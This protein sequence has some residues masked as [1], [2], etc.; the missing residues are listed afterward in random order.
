VSYPSTERTGQRLS[1]RGKQQ[2]DESR[3]Q[4]H[5]INA[6]TGEGKHF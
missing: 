2:V 3:L 4:A 6:R 5:E 1:S